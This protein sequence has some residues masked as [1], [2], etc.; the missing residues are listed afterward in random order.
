[1]DN[2]PLRD[3]TE[4]E[5]EAYW[6]DGAVCL[7]NILSLDWID[8]M[9]EALDRMLTNPGAMGTDIN[10]KGS[11]GRFSFETFMWPHDEDFRAFALDSPLAPIAAQIL[12]SEQVNFLF[13]FHFSKEP[14]TP[15]ETIW[16]QDQ[17]ANPVHGRNVAG[18]WVPLDVVTHESGA[19][20]YLRGSHNWNRWFVSPTKDQPTAVVENQY[21]LTFY[22]P[23]PGAGTDGGEEARLKK[24]NEKFELQPDFAAMHGEL[25]LLSF[26]SEPG[27]VVFNHLLTM[28][29]APGNYT[30]R[31]RRGVGARWVGDGTTFALREG[32][33]NARLP[34][35]P[36]LKDGDPFPS[37]HHMFPQV[38]PRP[39]KMQDRRA[40]E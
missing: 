4:D 12:R 37:D 1:M 21:E 15:H 30:D 16:H 3:V 23:E 31:R 10:P 2:L 7:R 11:P 25:D 5:I 6:K 20:E 38:W 28:H 34:W 18:S 36:G 39:V 35:D 17:G 29:W 8:R 33:P 27:D 19:P 24:Y 22:D 14:H 26:D 13:D 32:V 40:A 9:G